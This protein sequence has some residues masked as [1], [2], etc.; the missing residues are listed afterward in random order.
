MAEF[1]ALPL[2][3][4]AF[5]SDTTHLN[6]QQ[7]GAYL[8]LL[9]AAWRS[10]DCMLPDDDK[11]LARMARMDGRSWAANKETIMGFWKRDSETQKW[12]QRRLFDERNYA[13]DRR[14]RNVQ[15]GKASALKRN[16]RH[17]AVVQPKLNQKP[18]NPNPTP[19][20]TKVD[21]SFDD[22]WQRYPNKVAKA[23]AQKSYGQALVRKATPQQILDGLNT[24]IAKKPEG[25]PYA[26]ASTWLNGSRWNDEWLDQQPESK[27]FGS[28]VPQVFQPGETMSQYMRRTG[29][30]KDD[31]KQQTAGEM[32]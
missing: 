7:T 6:A 21:N 2:F 5:I 19:I 1:P 23:D 20:S 15:A 4:D 27:S 9:M 29:M 24:Y 10:P 32:V 16:G 30:T 12:Y 18:T 26:H 8:M 13:D 28:K 25:I 22:F 17:S 14:K 3:T 11:L 31:L